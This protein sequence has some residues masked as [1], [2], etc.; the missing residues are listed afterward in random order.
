MPLAQIEHRNPT[1]AELAP[2]IEQAEREIADPGSRAQMIRSWARLTWESDIRRRDPNAFV[3]AFAGWVL[4]LDYNAYLRS[5]VWRAI[6]QRKLETA[7]YKCECGCGRRAT[8]VHHRD[9]RPRVLA[10]E[11]LSPLVALCWQCHH[12]VEFDNRRRK[13]DVWQDKERVLAELVA[14]AGCLGPGRDRGWREL[15]Q[16]RA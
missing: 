16:M 14:G 15:R 3:V 1:P 5:P 8:L 13:R 7:D 12:V 11:D 6:R 4:N 9:Y 2:Y 10:G